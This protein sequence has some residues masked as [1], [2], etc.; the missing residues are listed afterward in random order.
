MISKY[1][2]VGAYALMGIAL[3]TGSGLPRSAW[4]RVPTPIEDQ[5]RAEEDDGASEEDSTD[6]EDEE[7][8]YDEDEVLA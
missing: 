6:G 8:I 4:D 2:L 1:L 3:A 5:I 7:G